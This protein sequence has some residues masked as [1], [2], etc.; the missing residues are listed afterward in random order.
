MSCV[1]VESGL[2]LIT[3]GAI[4]GSSFLFMKVA[5]PAFGPAALIEIRLLLAAIL[6]AAVATVSRRPLNWQSNWRHH[7]V[8][9]GVNSAIPFLCFAYAAQTLPASLLSLFNS[10]A[11]VFG[12]LVSAIWLQTPI[13]RKT[14]AGL[15]AG[16]SGVALLSLEHVLTIPVNATAA[17]VLL[18]IGAASIAPLC[19][20][21]AAT[22]IKWSSQRVDAFSNAHGAMW[23]ATLIAAPLALTSPPSGDITPLSIGA[24]AVLGLVCTGAAYLLQFRLF[25]D[26]G[27][28]RGLTVTYLIP[29]FGVLWG[30]L[31]LDEPVGWTLVA[32]GALLLL[33]TALVMGGFTLRTPPGAADPN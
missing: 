7:F 24:V 23:S 26:L 29:V 8:I 1:S 4:W 17:D 31:F 11:P 19:Y 13:S 6:L 30:V 22:Y 14:A 10:L 9:G 12:A 27:P 20:G 5:V 18:A 15:A 33:G 28:T 32:G 2:R 25:A 21:V 3:L 16:V